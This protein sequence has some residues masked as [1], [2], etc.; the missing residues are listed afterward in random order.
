M[1][2]RRRRCSQ[3]IKSI[4]GWYQWM[5]S[6]VVEIERKK[7]SKRRKATRIPVSLHIRSFISYG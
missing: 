7:K 1:R 4:R 6:E 3:N 5:Y 2:R